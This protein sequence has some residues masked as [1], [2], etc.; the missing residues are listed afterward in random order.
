MATLNIL[1]QL[2]YLCPHHFWTS[3]TYSHVTPENQTHI[4]WTFHPNTPPKNRNTALKHFI[5]YDTHSRTYLSGMVT[6]SSATVPGGGL[7]PF[8]NNLV[9][10]LFVTIMKA[11][12]TGWSP[13]IHFKWEFKFSTSWVH[14]VWISPSPTPSLYIT[15]RCG[16]APPL[17]SLYF[18][19]A[20]GK[21][22]S[23]CL[24]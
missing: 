15:I 5:R 4:Q 3:N 1:K 21:K 8:K 9:F 12:F 23:P 10:I 22:K 11:I 17:Y 14:T 13:Y 18:W 7:P 6:Q 20:S 16:R 24:C 2:S 19:R